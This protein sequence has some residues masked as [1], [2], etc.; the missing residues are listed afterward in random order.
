MAF[1][2]IIFSEERSFNQKNS[3]R[4]SNKDGFLHPPSLLESLSGNTSL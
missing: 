2:Q 1:P 3:P 4:I